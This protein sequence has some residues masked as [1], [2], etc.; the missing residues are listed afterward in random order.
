[1]GASPVFITQYEILRTSDY[2]LLTLSAPTGEV[3]D[4]KMQVQPVAQV[5]LTLSRFVEMAGLM[6]QIAKKIAGPSP[7]NA[8]RRRKEPGGAPGADS[9]AEEDGDAVQVPADWVIRH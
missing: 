2:V 4:G 1:M 5:A 9:D 7:P 6:S 8:W 3:E